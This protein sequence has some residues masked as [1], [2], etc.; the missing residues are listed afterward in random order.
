MAMAWIVV[1]DSSLARIFS[2]AQNTAD[3]EEIETLEHPAGRLHEQELTTDLPGRSF[4]SM[5]AGRHAMG[6]TV[7]PKKQEAVRFAKSIA[8]KLGKARNENR[9][10]KLILIAA[11]AMLGL[12]RE[13]LDKE[14]SKRV[15]E[16]ID[17]DLTQH[18][19]EDISN[20]LPEHIRE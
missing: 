20:H 2:S 9:F 18:S 17:K 16:T 1:A 7:E 12:L 19:I 6:Q 3:I 4:D 11:P 5:G 14:T 10:E 15:I 8:E 13:A